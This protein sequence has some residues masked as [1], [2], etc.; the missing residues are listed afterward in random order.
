[1]LGRVMDYQVLI[2][3]IFFFTVAYFFNLA[4]IFNVPYS[5]PISLILFN[6]ASLHSFADTAVIL[7]TIKPYRIY[8]LSLLEKFGLIKKNQW[9][10]AYFRKLEPEDGSDQKMNDK[11]TS[12][13]DFRKISGR[14]SF[15]LEI[16]RKW[17]F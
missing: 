1:M 5:G 10:V 6:F 3:C 14:K 16:F 8:C 12:D 17:D 15:E 13:T 11:S 2:N 7:Y 9:P 4:I